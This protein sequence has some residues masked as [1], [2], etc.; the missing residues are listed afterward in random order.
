VVC[1]V[2]FL[3]L[4]IA[5]SAFLI[6]NEMVLREVVDRLGTLLPV[7][8]AEMEAALRAVIAA[9]GVT[10]LVGTLILIF[11]ASQL[12]A[13]TRLV[14][15]RVFQHKGRGLIHG[16][17]FD[18]GMILCL[19]V[20]FLVSIGVTG[21]FAWVR[22]MALL[23]G[24]GALTPVALHWAGLALTVLLDTA[25]FVMIYRFVPNRRIR[26]SSVL[27]GGLATG[28][29]WEVAKQGF[30]WYIEGIGVYSAVYG[31]LGV[32]IAL[33]MWVYYSA[34]VFILGAALIRGLEEH[35]SRV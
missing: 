34:I 2:P 7:Y 25:L 35:R 26:W 13:A 8:H 10:T 22:A 14:L 20:G 1:I 28:V 11:F 17:L 23:V 29:L 5:G 21:V 30:R 32:T 27:V 19:T 15:N 31:S 33:M 4:M 12:F 16:M 3:L 18:L 9:R 6:S 24:R